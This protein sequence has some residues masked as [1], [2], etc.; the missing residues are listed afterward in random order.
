MASIMDMSWVVWQLSQQRLI[1]EV[2]CGA[3]LDG[4]AAAW[5]KLLSGMK[6]CAADVH[7][8]CVGTEL[9][10]GMVDSLCDGQQAMEE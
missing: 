7:C 8:N 6:D 9:V 4:H 10:F 3:S 5:Q 2:A 1:Q